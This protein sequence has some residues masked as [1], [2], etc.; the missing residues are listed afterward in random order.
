[1]SGR[2]AAVIVDD[3]AD[4]RGLLD[5]VLT[6]SGFE[7]VL[8]ENAVDGVAAVE[9]TDPVIT[10][11]DVAMPGMDGIA[12]ARRIRDVSDTYIVI[13][14]GQ[15]DEVDVVRGFNAGADD[16][17]IKP[18]RPR[19]FRARVETM[20]RRPRG[21][22]LDVEAA[23]TVGSLALPALA[24]AE[25][26]TVPQPHSDALG[27][28][29]V[30]GPVVQSLSVP[31]TTDQWISHGALRIEPATGAVVCDGRPVDL[32]DVEF[33]L[34]ATL[35]GSGRRVR[36][37]ANLVLTLRGESYVTTYFVSHD[38]KATV[39]EH[40]AA[41]RRKLGDTDVTPRWIE[42]VRGVGYRMVNG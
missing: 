15:D 41:L 16:Y 28:T 1:M 6:Q 34:L 29:V 42:T 37:T 11:L 19:E 24:T 35:I 25:A 12:A 9:D 7:T 33:A 5:R 8:A 30:D 23:P 2:P 14:S 13:L 40:L 3:D 17:L 10:V 21:R 26:P 39:I 32:D 4:I 18:V 36:S 31:V 22:H 27:R 20:L 38:D